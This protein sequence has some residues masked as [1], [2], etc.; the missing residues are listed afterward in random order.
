MSLVGQL[1]GGV[2]L[3]RIAKDFCSTAQPSTKADIAAKYDSW[4]TRNAPFLSR[5]RQ[6]FSR[7]NDRLK[8]EGASLAQMEPLV[9]Q[10]LRSQDSKAFCA[11]FADLLEMKEQQFTSDLRRLLEVVEYA[12]AELS[13]R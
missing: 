4:A 6:Q 11:S 7:A 12:D 1:Y 3:P 2:E 9:L 10:Q 8:P 13:K 5:A